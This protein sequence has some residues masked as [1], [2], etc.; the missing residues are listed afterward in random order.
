MLRFADAIQGDPEGL[1]S[2]GDG[3]RPAKPDPS[4][5]LDEQLTG[6]PVQPAHMLGPDRHDAES[7]VAASLAPS[8]LAVG[9]SKEVP[10]SLIKVAKRLLLHHLAARG[11]PGIVPPRGGELPAL[12]Q[13]SRCTHTPWSPP[14]LLLAG[15]VPHEPGMSTV[16]AQYRFLSSRRK[17]AVAGHTKTLSGTADIPEEVKRRVTP[18]PTPGVTTPRTA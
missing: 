2:V 10:H 16:F 4:A 8:G 13:V 6:F 3:T 15:E 5:L 9:A 7:F 14:Q 17:Q 12:L 11:K 18:C 1:H